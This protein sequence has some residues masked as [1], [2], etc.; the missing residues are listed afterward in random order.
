[1]AEAREDAGKKANLVTHLKYASLA[2]AEPLL[3][4]AP[5]AEEHG[6]A[7]AHR[8][9]AAR[10]GPFNS[11]KACVEGGLLPEMEGRFSLCWD[12]SADTGTTRFLCRAP[13]PPPLCTASPLKSRGALPPPSQRAWGS[14]GPAG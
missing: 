9:G 7:R 12:A 4:R 10:M 1:M 2:Q 11:M 8:E 3:R 5:R 6:A 13:M 14:A